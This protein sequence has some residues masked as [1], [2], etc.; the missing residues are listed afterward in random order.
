MIQGNF[1]VFEGID[2]AGTTTQATQLRKK[3]SDIGLPA[4]ITAEP[5]PGPV[6]AMI[7]QIIAGRLVVCGRHGVSAPSWITMSLLFGADRH[8]HIESEIL[9][10]LR[11]GVNVICDRYLHSALVYQSVSSGD[12]K[13]VEWIKEINR[14]AKKPDMVL[15]LKVNPAE[16]RKRCQSRD[17]NTEL[18]DDPEFQ[19]KLAT[20]YDDLANE[21]QD[22]EVVTID[23]NRP[24]QEV[25][26][27]CWSHV[28]RLR[29]CGGP[30]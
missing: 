14:H 6:G 17:Q 11:D 27:E 7:R 30:V 16:A 19:Q 12:D 2:G 10:N 23:G 8:D 21:V 18:F 5:S 1:I 26:D 15:Y 25:A 24:I 3:F 22:V 20:A 29:S 28:E 13:A 9:P 4:H